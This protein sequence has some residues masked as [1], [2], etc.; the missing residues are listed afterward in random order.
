MA[1]IGF[2]IYVLSNGTVITPERA[3]HL[4]ELKV[5]GVQVS[6]EGPQK[7][8]EAIRGPGSFAAS[9]AGI[10]TLLDAGVKVSL[11]AT[12]SR[13]NAGYFQD[14]VA[15]ARSLGV[16]RLG[17]SRLVPS[18]QGR[19]WLDQM[20]TTA[21]VKELY[22]EVLSLKV[23]GLEITT[24]DPMAAQIWTTAPEKAETFPA[25]GC[26]AGVAGLT[27]LADGTVVPCRR[28]NLP[29][30]QVGQDSLREIWAAS[31]ILEALRDKSRYAGKCG[32][33][34]RWADCRGCRAIAYE[35]ARSQGNP[36]FL[37]PDPQCFI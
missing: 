2:E 37:A 20:L 4:S 18:G 6:L 35:Y 8:H 22:E 23:D 17:F 27:L 26:S 19:V 7:I 14:L 36:D 34:A 30:G 10:R 9:L 15:L 28:L 21:Q 5:N 11:N 33:C 3:R 32:A 16:P 25:G 24:G 31:P 1:G 12:L 13:V 29:L